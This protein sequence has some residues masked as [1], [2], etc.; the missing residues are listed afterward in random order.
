MLGTWRAASLVGSLGL[1]SMFGLSAISG[2]TDRDLMHCR[3]TIQTEPEELISVRSPSR[4]F[5]YMPGA[6]ASSS[7][8]S[9]RYTDASSVSRG[10]VTSAWR[11]PLTTSTPITSYFPFTHGRYRTDGIN[12]MKQGEVLG[13]EAKLNDS[14]MTS[15]PQLTA[16]QFCLGVGIINLF[17]DIS[18]LAVL[19]SSV[20]K[21]HMERMQMVAS[22][23]MFLLGSL[24]ATLPLLR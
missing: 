6:S 8:Q 13:K 23:F 22:C 18:I 16:R 4:M 10:W 21:L 3:S 24:C 2:A 7:S 5:S 11:S 15:K 12:G 19:I 20:L 1:G 9:S 17:G 14:E